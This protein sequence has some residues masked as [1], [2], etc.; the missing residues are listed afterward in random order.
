MALVTSGSYSNRKCP[1][2]SEVERA[3]AEQVPEGSSKEFRTSLILAMCAKKTPET[4]HILPPDGKGRELMIF[5]TETPSNFISFLQPGED[6]GEVVDADW[7]AFDQAC[8]ED[9]FRLPQD[10]R[11]AAVEIRDKVSHFQDQPL[12]QVEHLLHFAVGKEKLVAWDEAWRW[13]KVAK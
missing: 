12:A 1:T 9:S 3:F 6:R 13:K 2:L 8:K 5:L 11:M 7:N 10:L 4:Y